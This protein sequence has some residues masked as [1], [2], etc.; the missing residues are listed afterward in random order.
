MV[1]CNRN[2]QNEKY[3]TPQTVTRLMDS[4][5]AGSRREACSNSFNLSV[6]PMSHN[7]I[8][9]TTC[10]CGEVR[11]ASQEREWKHERDAML[12]PEAYRVSIAAHRGNQAKL[13]DTLPLGGPCPE[14]Y[15]TLI[16]HRLHTSHFFVSSERSRFRHHHTDMCGPFS[17]W[18][19]S[20]FALNSNIKEELEKIGP[21]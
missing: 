17:C 10:G 3:Y 11:A 7:A 16:P 19:A 5:S 9:S 2:N 15:K 6:A 4:W 1:Y 12:K 8:T 14:E 20:A 13:H 18:S 21:P